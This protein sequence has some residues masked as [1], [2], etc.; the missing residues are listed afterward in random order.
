M[1]QQLELPLEVP[2]EDRAYHPH[3]GYSRILCKRCNQVLWH[4]IH[5]LS[6]D[7]RKRLTGGVA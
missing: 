4:P 7:E 6:P 2:V 3:E 1:M 5:G